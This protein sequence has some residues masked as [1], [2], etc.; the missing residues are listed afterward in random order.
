MTF[1]AEALLNQTTE[2]VMP[3]HLP[4][5]PEGEYAARIG[6][7]PD[8]VTVEGF[9]GKKDTTKT[10]YRATVVWYILDEGLK[11]Q[12]GRDSVRV[13]QR[14]FVDLDSNTGAFL[15]GADKNV[16]LGA[17]REAVGLNQGTFSLARLRG[18]GPALVR[19]IQTADEKDPAIK[20]SEVS[21]VTKL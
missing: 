10:F 21:R 13:R 4:P 17:L 20:Y 12:L 8:D 11:S 19:I 14:F 18:A 9:K 6:D 1:D 5:V 2:T 15:E 7:G 3:T 16:Q